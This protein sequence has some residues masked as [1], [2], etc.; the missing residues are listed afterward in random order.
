M[1]GSTIGLTIGGASKTLTLINTDNYASEYYLR[2]ATQEFRMKVRHSKASGKNGDQDR[3]NVELVRKVF[4][5]ATT[6]EYVEK[7]YSVRQ[8]DPGRTTVDLAAAIDAWETASTNAMLT[9]MENWES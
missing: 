5:T 2:E 1:L 6:P 3:H 4:A 7:T 8:A 9:K